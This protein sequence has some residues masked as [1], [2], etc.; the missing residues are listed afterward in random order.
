[1]PLS[2]EGQELLEALIA[3]PEGDAIVVTYNEQTR[4]PW[5]LRHMRWWSGL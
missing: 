1:M 5:D 2:K 4:C 3:S